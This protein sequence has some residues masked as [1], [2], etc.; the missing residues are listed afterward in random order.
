MPKPLPTTTSSFRGMIEGNYLYIDKTQYIY[1]LVKNPKGAWFLSRPR[2]FGKSLLISTLEELFRGQRDLFR[3]LWIDQSDYDWATYPV[4]RLDFNLY[5]STSA[6]ELQSNIKRYL[7]YTA[8]H[9]GLTLPDGP[10][11]AQFGDL[12]MT[13]GAD[14]PVIILIDEYDKPLIDN[15]HN[16]PEAKRMR[17]TLKGFYGVI[18]A[19]DRYIRLSFITGIS[20]FSKVGVFSDLN[21]L[22]DLTMNTTFAT[23]LGLTEAELQQNLADYITPFATKENLNE[24]DLLVK[25]RHW[26]DGFCFAPEAE[27]VYNPYSTLHLFYNQRFANYWFESGSPSYLIDLIHRGNYD[28]EQLSH[29]E[30]G[31]LAFSTYELDRLA[32]VPL[33]FQ[34]GYLTIKEYKADS[35]RFLLDYPNYE[36]ENAFMVYLLDA[37]SNTQQ[38]FSEA[39]LWRLLDALKAADL[40]LFFNILK[41]LFANIDYDLHLDYEKYYQTIFYLLFKLLGL[42]IAAEVKTNDGRIDAVVELDEQIY[43]FEFKLDQSAASALQQMKD[44]AYYRKYQ[45][46]NKPIICVG[47]NFSTKTRTVEEWKSAPF[48]SLPAPKGKKTRRNSS[49]P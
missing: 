39:H 21:N 5:P 48:E 19:L 22:T 1:D 11:Y 29:L 28:L 15:L 37:F 20:K 33:L 42:Q 12:I 36:V 45:L 24:R 41:V 49:N 18:K 4:I 8:R 34:T 25:I 46:R 40:P 26:Y 17:D 38:G 43:L 13:L 27:S 30:L 2:R 47:A 32:I 3:G 16:L 6:E 23:A 9:Y 7:A 35:Q 44:Q 10:Y 31:E 14:Q